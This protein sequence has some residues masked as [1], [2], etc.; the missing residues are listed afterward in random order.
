MPTEPEW[1]YIHQAADKFIKQLTNGTALILTDL[2]KEIVISDIEK[3][4]AEGDPAFIIDSIDWADAFDIR[5]LKLH[6]SV[7]NSIM[8]LTGAE[9]WKRLDIP[10][11]FN[12]RNPYAEKWVSEHGAELVTAVSKETKLAIR[13]IVHDGFKSGFPPREM[14]KRIRP[15][16]GLTDRNANAALRYW[17][18]L[19]EDAKDLTAQRV[20]SMADGYAR[21]LLRRR[22]MNIAR[23]ETIN[24]ANQGTLSAWNTAKDDGFILPESQKEW[25]AA[26]QSDRL[27]VHCRPMDG[28]KVNLDEKFHSKTLSKDVD[29]PT[30]HPQCRCSVGLVTPRIA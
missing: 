28:Q 30:L 26:T 20:D 1:L 21:R 23:T 2:Q 8:A 11:S 15:M 29:G 12:L 18:A 16:I 14:A 22:A 3:A 19:N 13:S 17:L 7:A 10:I 4:L 9:A 25:I 6:E 24:S 5:L 27:C